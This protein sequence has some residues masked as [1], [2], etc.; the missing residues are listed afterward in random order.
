MGKM[1]YM[2]LEKL[3]FSFYTK[4]GYCISCIYDKQLG[5]DFGRCLTKQIASILHRCDKS[6]NYSNERETYRLN[7]KRQI[8]MSRLSVS[9]TFD[10]QIF[11]TLF[12]RYYK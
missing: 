2:E 7:L 1:H 11:T 4:K 8:K 5:E 6:L 9:Q 3:A 12:S 10:L